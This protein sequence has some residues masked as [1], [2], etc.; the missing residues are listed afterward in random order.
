MASCGRNT[1]SFDDNF[2]L[3]LTSPPNLEVQ[4]LDETNKPRHT[5]FKRLVLVG[6]I[7]YKGLSMLLKQ[8][9]KD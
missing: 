6:L 9:L 3:V 1:F 5:L 8:Y 4:V 7:A 2:V